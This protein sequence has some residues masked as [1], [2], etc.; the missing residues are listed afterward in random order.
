MRAGYFY[1]RVAQNPPH[2]GWYCS[3]KSDTL[4]I[5]D[6]LDCYKRRWQMMLR[7]VTPLMLLGS[8]IMLVSA[9]CWSNNAYAQEMQMQMTRDEFRNA[10]VG[11][12]AQGV[13]AAVGR[14]DSISKTG[15]PGTEFWRYNER[16]KDTITNNTDKVVLVIFEKGIVARV[17]Y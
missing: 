2:G 5:G 17:N 13:I 9:L 15:G 6:V 8:V 1:A 14:P 3:R 4:C 7:R 12:D 16:T 10:V 11:K